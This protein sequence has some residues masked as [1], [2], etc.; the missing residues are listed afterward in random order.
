MLENITPNRRRD[1]GWPIFATRL[2]L[3]RL[4]T[5]QMLEIT[6]RKVMHFGR[7]TI[8]G[9]RLMLFGVLTLEMLENIMRN[10]RQHWGVHLGEKKY[11]S[12]WAFTIAIF[13]DG[14][15][16][17]DVWQKLRFFIQGWIFD[18]KSMLPAGVLPSSFFGMALLLETCDK[19]CSGT[20][21]GKEQWRFRWGPV[22]ICNL[23]GNLRFSAP[24]ARQ[25]LFSHVSSNNA[26]SCAKCRWSRVKR[27]ISFQVPIW[28]GNFCHTSAEIMQMRSRNVVGLEWN[29]W[30]PFR[31]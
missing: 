28:D 20:F 29:A 23:D 3:F 15:I 27:M 1:F 11:A 6:V 24:K 10:R 4:L 21:G 18:K 30:F 25:Q 2:M 7:W 16:T 8:F 19:S 13:R 12:R 26:N 9:T 17:A 14:I 22:N 5:L 31:S